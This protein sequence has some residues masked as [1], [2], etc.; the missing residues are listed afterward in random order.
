MDVVRIFN[1]LGNQMSQ[2][3]FYYAKKKRHPFRTCYITNLY[4][5]ENVYIMGMN[6][7]V[8]LE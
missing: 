6:W 2:Y 4:D 7:N 3:A 1:G 8:S 5:S